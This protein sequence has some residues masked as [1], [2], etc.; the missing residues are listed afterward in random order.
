MQQQTRQQHQV[1]MQHPHQP[2]MNRIPQFTV[3][4]SFDSN[5]D[6]NYQMHQQ[7]YAAGANMHKQIPHPMPHPQ[8][9]ARQ[10]FPPQPMPMQDHPHTPHFP[11]V[12]D[13]ALNHHQQYYMPSS[14]APT[15]PVAVVF[16]QT[17]QSSRQHLPSNTPVTNT[18][19][20][21]IMYTST[22]GPIV[23]A[24]T[25][26]ESSKM[27]NAYKPGLYPPIPPSSHSEY[28]QSHSEYNQSH[29]EYKQSP[30]HVYKNNVENIDQNKRNN[31]VRIF[32]IIFLT[33][34][35]VANGLYCR[36]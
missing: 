22:Q 25:S 27:Q 17:K 21:A 14:H 29:S 7:Q 34:F 24:I 16:P 10:E 3:T 18:V 6:Q 11:P 35:M 2:V 20:S 15:P 8:V 30:G 23:S 1:Q 12:H 13:Q 5:P 19:A 31:S 33:F 26:A 36:S 32:I 28:K 4:V 9:F